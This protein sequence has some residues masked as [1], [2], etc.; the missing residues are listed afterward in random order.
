MP[1]R[2]E[3][4]EGGRPNGEGLT[5]QKGRKGIFKGSKAYRV[6]EDQST[7]SHWRQA[8]LSLTRGGE[9]DPAA[10]REQ[11]ARKKKVVCVVNELSLVGKCVCVCVVARTTSGMPCISGRRVSERKEGERGCGWTRWGKGWRVAQ[12]RDHREASLVL[13]LN[14][15]LHCLPTASRKHT[16][17]IAHTI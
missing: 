16:Q 10:N 6:Q 17:R 15:T 13:V 8:T 3:E 5:G 12:T 14:L 7:N 4:G 11:S 9:R 2:G 1:P